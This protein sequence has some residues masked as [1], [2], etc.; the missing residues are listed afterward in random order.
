MNS[1]SI[2]LNKNT[3]NPHNYYPFID[4]FRGVAI[5]WVISHHVVQFF[6]LEIS[7]GV[8]Y[9]IAQI[10][11]LG[12]DLFFVTSGFLI[13][14]LLMEEFSSGEMRLKRFYARRFFKIVPHYLL[15][16]IAAWGFS[17]FL[18]PQPSMNSAQLLSYLT[19]M[20]SYLKDQFTPLRHLWSI[21]IEEH[22]YLLYPLLLLFISKIAPQKEDRHKFIILSLG[23]LILCGNLSRFIS[24]Q[25]INI[26]SGVYS[27]QMTHVRFD[28]LI[29]GCLLRFSERYFH[30]KKFYGTIF[31][32]FAI[33]FFFFFMISFHPRQWFYSTMAYLGAGFTLAAAL[34][35]FKPIFNLGKLSFLRWVGKSSYGIYLWHHILIFPILQMAGVMKNDWKVAFL[36][37][38]LSVSGGAFLTLTFEK[39]FLKLRQQWV[40]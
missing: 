39:F 19:F 34:C 1:P 13:T 31:L 10:G 16:V 24:F 35:G 40:P 12:V 36:Y 23:F 25:F 15:A 26:E 33:V 4:A 2:K 18:T 27:Y 5:L 29:F 8:L 14:G 21:S 11:F 3:S 32:T 6:P 20:Q 9:R 38:I 7:H 30:H 28:A 37:V 17:L 22:F